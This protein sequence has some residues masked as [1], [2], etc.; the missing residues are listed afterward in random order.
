MDGNNEIIL[1]G[2]AAEAAK[3]SHYNHGRAFYCF[4][5]DVKRLSGTVD[6]LNVL[7]T[8]DAC[9]G[10]LPEEREEITV[11]GE[12]RSFNNRSGQ[13]SRLVITAFARAVL[14]A[15]EEDDNRVTLAGTLC[16]PP[17]FR[18]TPLGR[19]ICDMILAVSR[20]YGWSDYLPCIAWGTLARRCGGMDVGDRVALRGRLQSRTYVKRTDAGEQERV[21]FE[22]SVM[23]MDWKDLNA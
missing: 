8:Q 4:P 2:R 15:E 16:K 21:A 18:H 5:I 22:I 14:R 23:D 9:G 19:D 7:A 1:H 11:L 6:R 17:V 3:L 13:G 20:R 10:A 12:V